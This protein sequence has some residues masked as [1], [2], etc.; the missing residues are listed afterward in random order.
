L[1]G[2]EGDSDG[3]D[4]QLSPVAR[5]AGHQRLIE[6][7]LKLAPLGVGA[8]AVMRPGPLLRVGQGR[9]LGLQLADDPGGSGAADQAL[10]GRPDLASGRASTSSKKSGR[11]AARTLRT[12][13]DRALSVGRIAG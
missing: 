2:R 7:A 10:L 5:D 13:V 8:E 1:H 12:R 6:D 9:D 3:G 11:E 4:D